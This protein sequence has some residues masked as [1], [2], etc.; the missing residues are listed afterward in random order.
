LYRIV[1]YQVF[2]TDDDDI[3]SK[4]TTIKS[5]TKEFP[6]TICAYM[7]I[8]NHNEMSIFKKRLVTV[9]TTRHN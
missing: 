3:G 7:F 4:H 9:F 5:T 1:S 6:L 8:G 2:S